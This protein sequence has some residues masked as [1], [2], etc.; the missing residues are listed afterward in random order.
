MHGGNSEVGFPHLL[1]QPF[2]LI[3]EEREREREKRGSKLIN[4]QI[5]FLTFLLVLQNMT[6][7][8]IVRVSYKSHRVSNFHS[9]FST[10]TKNCLIP[11]R[12][13]SS[14]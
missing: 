11:S 4:K 2:Y 10:A 12:V 14:L 13:N 6:A 8:V 3:N 9:S 7:C 1:C 5:I